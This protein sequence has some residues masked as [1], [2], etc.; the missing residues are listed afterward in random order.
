MS[1]LITRSGLC[2]TIQD[3]GRFGYRR[4]GIGPNGPMDRLS[5]GMANALLGKEAGAALLELTFPA[6]TLLFEAP[7]LICLAGADLTATAGGIPVPLLQPCFVPAGSELRFGTPR[8]GRWCY[9]A[10]LPEVQADSWLNSC[11]TDLAAGAGG[12]GGRRLQRGD[13]IC[14]ERHLP[15][16]IRHGAVRLLPWQAAAALPAR[17]RIRFLPGPEWEELTEQSRK[18]LLD[19]PFS[20]QAASNR[21]GYRLDG[22]GLQ[23]KQTDPQVSSAVTAGTLQLPPGGQLIALMAGHQTTGGYPRVGTICSADLPLLAQAGPGTHVRFALTR[24]EDA[25]ADLIKQE[26][27]LR[28]LRLH[29]RQK[30]DAWLAEQGLLL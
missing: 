10:T 2:D 6:A 30:L 23:V 21:M 22:P 15:A 20:V 26:A 18:Q 8:S 28:Q 3:G 24:S 16:N 13:R 17:N 19:A 27:Y 1:L 11:S 14:F 29:S 25:I 12:L 7:V 5:A 9:L 4:L